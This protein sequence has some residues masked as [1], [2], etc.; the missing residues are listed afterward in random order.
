MF[1]FEV[2]DDPLDNRDELVD[3]L[4]EPVVGIRTRR[5]PDRRLQE[6]GNSKAVLGQLGQRWG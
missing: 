3:C 2:L 4:V 5:L 6:V 1:Q